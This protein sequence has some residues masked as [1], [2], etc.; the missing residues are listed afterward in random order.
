MVPACSIF[1]SC[2]IQILAPQFS[3]TAMDF[4]FPWPAKRAS[5]VE[6]SA[7]WG[8]RALWSRVDRFF[9]WAQGCSA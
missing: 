8:G 1:S 4:V 6:V 9:V 7:V 5:C 3:P 2:K